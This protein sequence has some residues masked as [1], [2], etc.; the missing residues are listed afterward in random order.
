MS[1]NNPACPNIRSKNWKYIQF[2]LWGCKNIRIDIEYQKTTFCYKLLRKRSIYS[3]PYT[4]STGRMPAFRRHFAS[5]FS[6]Q[7][8][9]RALFILKHSASAYA[10]GTS[11]MIS[12]NSMIFSIK[13]VQFDFEVLL[14]FLKRYSEGSKNRP[15]PRHVLIYF[16]LD[17]PLS[18]AI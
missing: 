15:F 1:K 10:N 14:F 4:K 9:Y 12:D 8:D 5:A 18:C 11:R 2:F 7:S 6:A 16:N 3:F 13:I 17:S